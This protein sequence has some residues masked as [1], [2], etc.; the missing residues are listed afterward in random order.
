MI[1]KLLKLSLVCVT[2]VIIFTA[3]P[4]T[5]MA[6][7]EP[8]AG[9]THDKISNSMSSTGG[10]EI[11]SFSLDVMPIPGYKNLG[12]ANVTTNLMIRKEPGEDKKILGKL[13]KN[14]GCE[15]LEEENGWTKIKAKTSSKDLIGYVKSEF[16]I[17]GVEAFQLAIDVGN[18]VATA[19]VDG[20]NVRGE[21]NTEARII[22]MIAKGEQLVILDSNV[23]TADTENSQWVKVSVDS[24][25]Q[26]DEFAYVARQ[27]IKPSFELI[28]AVTMEEIQYGEGVSKTRIDIV[29]FAKQYLGEA[30]VWGGTRLGVG[31]DCS[32]FTQAIYRHFDIYIPRTSGSQG[33]DGVSISRDELKPGDLVFYG[34]SGGINHVAMYIGNSK[35]IHASNRRDGIKISYINYRSP[36]RYRRYLSN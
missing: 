25:T 36:V 24:D 11:N 32:G 27:Y 8:V 14:G 9:F 13:P 22:D 20:L 4:K 3:N 30:Y 29:E 34:G 26:E 31:V 16:L 17:T 28:R 6:Y 18:Y 7:E 21:P 2:G 10:A 35:V 19:D 23:V 5:V 1:R 15:I 33:S 12:I